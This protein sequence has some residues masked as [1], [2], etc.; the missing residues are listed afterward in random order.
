MTVLSDIKVLEHG[1]EI[2]SFVL[3]GLPI[4]RDD[5]IDHLL[6]L[7]QVIQVLSSCQGGVIRGD[8]L[9]HRVRVLVYSLHRECLVDK[10]A[11]GKV[12]ELAIWIVSLVL[13][14]QSLEL[15]ISVVEVQHGKNGLELIDGDLP[16]SQLVEISEEFLNPN[17][18]HDHCC[19]EPPLYV[20]R[21]VGNVDRL[22]REPVFD[23]IDPFGWPLKEIAL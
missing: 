6:F 18:L 10:V 22:L 3:D 2:E 13:F 20:L 14:S 7:S 4:L 11:E 16:F 23:D 19:L 8:G 1:F 5:F 21:V 15:V 17:S 12:V 9:H